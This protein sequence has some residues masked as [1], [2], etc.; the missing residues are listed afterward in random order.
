MATEAPQSELK[1]NVTST[2]I[3][4]IQVPSLQPTHILNP[5]ITTTPQTM[6]KT[7]YQ[8]SARLDLAAHFLS[9]VEVIRY[10]NQTDMALSDI[11]LVVQANQEDGVFILKNLTWENGSQI[12]SYQWAGHNIRILLNHPLPIGNTVNI[13]VAYELTYPTNS[14]FLAIPAGK[15]TWLIGIRLF[16]HISPVLVG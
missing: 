15:P 7:F 1:T 13:I 11:L 4:T 5:T 12:I 9:T 16:H 6:R 14:I 3:N 2:P 8:L 10:N